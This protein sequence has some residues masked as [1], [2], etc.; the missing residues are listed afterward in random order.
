MVDCRELGSGDI[1][2]HHRWWFSLMPH[3][4]GDSAGIANN[5][6]KYIVDL[7]YSD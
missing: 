6:W 7:N 1:R 2:A 4:I 3:T 5:W